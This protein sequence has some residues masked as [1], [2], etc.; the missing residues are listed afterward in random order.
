MVI[1]LNYKIISYGG[2]VIGKIR[3]YTMIFIFIRNMM[4]C[5]TGFRL[6]IAFA[7]AMHIATPALATTAG[8]YVVLE[9]TT[10]RIRGII[11]K[12]LFDDKPYAS[13]KGIPYAE[14]PVAELRFK[15][16]IF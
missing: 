15:V 2:G 16:C 9:T 10:G 14:P 13:Y 1:F 4:I 7:F 11:G 5:F 12:T 6:A 3:I 8:K